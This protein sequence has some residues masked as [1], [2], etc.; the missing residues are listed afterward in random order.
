MRISNLKGLMVQERMNASSPKPSKGSVPSGGSTKPSFAPFALG[1]HAPSS[2][3][4][5]RRIAIGGHRGGSLRASALACE[6][7]GK[8]VRAT[9]PSGSL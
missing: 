4:M 8:L 6:R 1:L 2:E 9:P 3:E 7:A 5:Q